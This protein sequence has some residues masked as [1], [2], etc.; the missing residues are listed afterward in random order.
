MIYINN[1][2]KLDKFKNMS[3]YC[4]IADFDHT[5]TTKDSQPSYGIIPYFLGGECLKERIQ[6][7]N[8]YRPIELDY[9]LEREEKLRLMREWA[10]KSFTL[11]S[12]YTTEEIIDEAIRSNPNFHLKDGVK[13]FLKSTNENNV[14]VIIMSAGIGNLIKKFLEVENVFFDN[15]K[16][17]SNFFE[18]VSGKPYIDL[19]TIMATSN[20]D[21]SKIPENLRYIIESKKNILL[22][23][24]IVEDIEM[25]NKAQL[26][27]TLTVGFLDHNIDTNLEM[28]NNNYDVV[29]ANGE[30]FYKINEL[31]F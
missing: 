24:D 20:K 7:F 25:I 2:E 27:K 22:L 13:E 14:P 21:Y 23:G 9:T 15:I 3:N 10:R 5:L 28:Y 4:V 18:F 8:H 16:I 19:D 30:N 12:R 17:V 29:L 1:R 26:Y 6:I 11:L 31:L